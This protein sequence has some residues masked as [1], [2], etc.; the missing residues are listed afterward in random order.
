MYKGSALPFLGK[1]VSKE[2]LSETKMAVPSSSRENPAMW[3]EKTDIS[4]LHCYG[5]ENLWPVFYI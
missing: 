5:V 2:L 3:D 4:T 1:R